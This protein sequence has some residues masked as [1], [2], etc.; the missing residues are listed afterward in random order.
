VS[1]ALEK[2]YLWTLLGTVPALPFETLLGQARLG[3]TV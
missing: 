1:V 2:L 3:E